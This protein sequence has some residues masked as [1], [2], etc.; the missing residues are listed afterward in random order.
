M[1]RER[2]VGKQISIEGQTCSDIYGPKFEDNNKYK[3]LVRKLNYLTVTR[4]NIT[5]T[6]D[7]VSIHRIVSRFNQA[8]CKILRYLKQNGWA[9]HFLNRE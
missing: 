6:V 8:V 2:P 5:F 1:M 7:A 3:S 4:P 9:E